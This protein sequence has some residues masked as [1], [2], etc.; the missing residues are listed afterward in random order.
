MSFC[1]CNI[2]PKLLGKKARSERIAADSSIGQPSIEGFT[3][4][5]GYDIMTNWL[6]QTSQHN[7]SF[8]NFLSSSFHH[9]SSLTFRVCLLARLLPDFLTL[10]PVGSEAC[11]GLFPAWFIFSSHVYKNVCDF[12]INWHLQVHRLV[13]YILLLLC[14]NKKTVLLAES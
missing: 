6:S 1:F 5:R 7:A 2:F 14:T 9:S 4:S 12:I 3:Q 8:M 11:G 13:G 10:F